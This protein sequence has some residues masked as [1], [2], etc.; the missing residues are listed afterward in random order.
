MHPVT[1]FIE[2]FRVAG[3]VRIGPC[4]PA[5]LESYSRKC[6]YCCIIGQIK[7][8]WW[9]CSAIKCRIP[10]G[11]LQHAVTFRLHNTRRA[12]LVWLQISFLRLS[13][14]IV[15]QVSVCQKQHEVTCCFVLTYMAG[16]CNLV[17]VSLVSRICEESKMATFIIR[18]AWRSVNGMHC[19]DMLF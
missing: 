4:C 19:I 8:W 7:W 18:M 11:P 13:C 14:P 5:L 17:D 16:S 1:V 2:R 3:S 9:W 10:L 12:Q 15:R 6:A